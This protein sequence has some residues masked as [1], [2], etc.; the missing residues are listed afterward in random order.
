MPQSRRM[1]ARHDPAANVEAAVIPIRYG[2]STEIAAALK[3]FITDGGFATDFPRI[4]SL[5]LVDCPANMGKLREIVMHL[6]IKGEAGWPVACLPCRNIDAESLAAELAALMPV[7]GLPAIA[8]KAAGPGA[9]AAAAAAMA[10]GTGIRLVP[11]KRLQMLV[12]SAPARDILNEITTWIGVLDQNN[13]SEKE[14]VFFYN[15]RHSTSAH[16]AEM[17]DTFFNTVTTLASTSDSQ[18]SGTSGSSSSQSTFGGGGA[19]SR[20]NSSNSASRSNSSNAAS[21]NNAT[22]SRNN[23]NRGGNALPPG[24]NRAGIA[25]AAGAATTDDAGPKTIFDIPVTVYADSYQNRLALRTTPR[26]Y[27]MVKALLERMDV[28]PRQ[29]KI[30]AIIAEITL[31]KTTEFGFNYAVSNIKGLAANTSYNINTVNG[32]S[33]SNGPSVFIP[34]TS[35]THDTL[36]NAFVDSGAALLLKNSSD[37]KIG[38][39]RAVAGETN[40]RVLSAPEIVAKNDEPAYINVGNRIPI[41]SGTSNTGTTTN[42]NSTTVADV[43][44]QDT[45]VKLTV[46]PHITAGNEVSMEIRQEVSK[47]LKNVGEQSLS[48]IDSPIIQQRDLQTMLIVPDGDTVLM[49]GMIETSEDDSHSGIP[50]LMDIPWLG[51]LFRTNI[52]I[53]GRTELLIL[54]TVNVLDQTSNADKLA[55]RYQAALKEVQDKTAR[56]QEQP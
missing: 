48:N 13:E 35:T 39:I 54:I 41:L 40:V 16:L 20:N 10:G 4:N 49:G 55:T 5:L 43:Q 51:V 6:D 9:A 50:W 46:T 2:K 47:A 37:N 1:F 38:L 36:N 15:V 52:K 42:N 8:E 26:V 34:A 32:N 17:L 29:V 28:Q 56:K 11:L 7:L 23:A 25:G 24:V 30:Q 45:G 18:L 44:Y 19:S 31:N 3:P 21:R 33:L 14:S 27:A 22:A 12:V 53:R